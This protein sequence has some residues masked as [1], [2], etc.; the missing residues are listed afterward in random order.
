MKQSC[1]NPA[2][3]KWLHGWL[4]SNVTIAGLIFSLLIVAQHAPDIPIM[5]GHVATAGVVARDSENPRLDDHKVALPPETELVLL[6]SRPPNPVAPE[7]WRRTVDGWEH[8]STWASFGPSISQR[9]IAQR[10]QEPRWIR[11]AF[12]RI[13]GISPLLIGMFQLTAIAAIVYV[14]QRRTIS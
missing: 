14:A 10:A 6:T 5:S 4:R 2:E 3:L 9:I 11:H 12:I 8:V 7:G 1:L 13:L